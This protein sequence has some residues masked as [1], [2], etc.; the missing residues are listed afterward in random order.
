[1]SFSQQPFSN[2]QLELLKL[3]ADD[4]PEADLIEIKRMLAAYRLRKATEV[5]DAQWDTNNW[6]DDDMQRLLHQHDRTPYR[7]ARDQGEQS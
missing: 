2:V 6:T 3:F 5:A 1:M 4:V 7:G